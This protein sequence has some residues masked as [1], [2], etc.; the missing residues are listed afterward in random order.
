MIP[1][2]LVTSTG[3]LGEN[4]AERIVLAVDGAKVQVRVRKCVL[5]AAQQ[6][7]NTAISLVCSHKRGGRTK[8]RPFCLVKA[9]NA[10]PHPTPSPPTMEERVTFDSRE[11]FR[12]QWRLNLL[13]K[14]SPHPMPS[15]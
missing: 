6:P 9:E 7:V 4:A 15:S 12:G 14:E 10:P 1:N 2:G 11:G 13:K 8:V 3:D 5:S